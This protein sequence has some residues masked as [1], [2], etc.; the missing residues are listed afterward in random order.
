MLLQSD[1]PWLKSCGVYAVGAL[2]LEE[3]LPEVEALAA[4]PDALLRETVKRWGAK[5]GS[6]VVLDPR[7][8][9]VLALW[10]RGIP[11]SISAGVG[12]KVGGRL[13]T[14]IALL[15]SHT[16]P[17]NL[18]RP[19]SRTRSSFERPATRMAGEECRSTR[20]E[21]NGVS[22]ASLPAWGKTQRSLGTPSA[23]ARSTSGRRDSGRRS[24][25]SVSGC[26]PRARATE[27]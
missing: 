4:N 5:G 26:S 7:T 8:G 23:W 20:F 22:C 6:A 11:L 12:R 15:S 25:A 13:A 24:I 18:R 16:A 17:A 10:L 27:T 1:D 9:G 21:T 14:R 3:L 19:A 2:D